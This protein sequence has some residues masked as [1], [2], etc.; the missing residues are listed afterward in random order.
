MLTPITANYEPDGDDWKVSVTRDDKTLTGRAPGLI[1]A[2]DTADQL[3]EKLAPKNDEEN[4]PTVVHLLSGD[5]VAFSTAYLHARHG[6]PAG[7]PTEETGKNGK[8]PAKT[9][10]AAAQTGTQEQDTTGK[11]DGE[12]AAK[13][14]AATHQAAAA[15]NGSNGSNGSAPQHTADGQKVEAADDAPEPAALS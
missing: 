13:N 7:R 3:V 4:A 14:G 2:R 8:A 12:D 6:G 15:M 11:K 5:P 10:E 9:N 1:A